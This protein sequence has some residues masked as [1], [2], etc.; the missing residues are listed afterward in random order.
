MKILKGRV[1]KNSDGE[2]HNG[3]E[4]IHLN[5]N[6]LADQ[7]FSS[8]FKLTQKKLLN[9]RV[10]YN[11]EYSFVNDDDESFNMPISNKHPKYSALVIKDKIIGI[12]FHP[13][14]SQITGVDL[15][16]LVL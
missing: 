8:E 3:W 5:R 4:T 9:G 10:F 13:E 15:A 7:T 1:V 16:S 2:S 6:E 11:H 14:K 12:Q